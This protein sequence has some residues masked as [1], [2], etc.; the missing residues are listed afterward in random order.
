MDLNG[1]SILITGGTGS[2]GQHFIKTV[3]KR[4][5]QV[6]RI[7]VFSRDEQKQFQ[8]AQE[9]SPVEYPA[10][11]Y[12]IGDVRDYD[13]LKRAYEG[14]DYVVHAAAM[15]HVPIAEYNPMECIKTNVYGA[16]NVIN[17][18][19]DSNISRVVALSTDKASGAINLYGATKLCSDKLFI[20]ANNF[21]G[22]RDINFSVVR[23]G[24]VM[25]SNGS[26]I[27]FFLKQRKE[28]VLTITD[29][30]MT[31]FNITLD[32][33]VELV[34]KALD[35]AW[36]GEIFVPR[37]PSYRITDLAEAIAPECEQKFTGIRAGE[38]VHEEMVSASD[39]PNTVC[40]DDSYVILPHI[41]NWNM[42]AY[43]KQFNAQPVELDFN[44]NSGSNDQFLSI[45]EIREL[46]RRHIAPSFSV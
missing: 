42:D 40:I 34:L 4:W 38:K 13:R 6:R 35:S 23:Y 36:G 3:L 46:I 37:I 19:L 1:K 2:F 11:R 8:M 25:G 20:A 17:A 10:L 43:M 30:Q 24:N 44:Y 33:G 16:Q 15:K 9:L 32:H 7:V 41:P 14:I 26:V 21:K 45:S 28:G 22:T 12:F 18:A 29:P 27:P 5:P 39:A 31:R